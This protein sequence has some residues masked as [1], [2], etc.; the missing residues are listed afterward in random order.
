M[1]W[2]G[3]NFYEKNS[4]KYFAQ[5]SYM[6][7]LKR[8]I[9]STGDSTFNFSFEIK[10]SEL[11][12][13]NAVSTINVKKINRPAFVNSNIDFIENKKIPNLLRD[14]T[15]LRMIPKITGLTNEHYH[16]FV[17]NNIKPLPNNFPYDPSYDRWGYLKSKY[18]LTIKDYHYPGDNI[19][20]I[21][22]LHTDA[23]LNYFNFG[24]YD[25]LSFLKDTINKLLKIS[26]RKIIIR[27]H[28][29]YK[30]NP[31][32]D[33]IST[34]L[35]NFFEKT[36]RVSISR[37]EKL[38]DDF[39]VSRCVISYNSNASI[40]ALMYGIN[41]INLSDA[42]PCLTT[43]NVLDDLEKLKEINRDDFLKKVAFLHWETKELQSKEN[44]KYLYK[45]IKKTIKNLNT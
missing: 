40:E 30:L 1:R 8:M 35:I 26:D 20:L 16:C 38:E 10:E 23:S 33:K 9:E 45:L 44:M 18:N 32:R 34:S 25:Y 5:N 3:Y 17:F 15:V 43:I 13:I 39:D 7:F 36:N 11:S 41:V 4:E 42:N 19:L 24:N 37:N 21:L 14:Q 31:K 29:E 12:K 22:Q 6:K 2:I 27:A 28:P